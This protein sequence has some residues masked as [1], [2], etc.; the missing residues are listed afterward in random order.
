MGAASTST[1]TGT[2][3]GTN[4]NDDKGGKPD[5]SK[6]GKGAKPDPDSTAA[7]AAGDDD[8]EQ[9]KAMARKHEREN[10]R[11]LKEL[12][13]IRTANESETEKKIREAKDEGRREATAELSKTLVSEAI[14]SEAAT[15]LADADD[16]ALISAD[17]RETFVDD[18]G[19]IDRK[20]IQAA[21]DSLVKA[22][23][24]L[25]PKGKAAP[26]PG[27]AGTSSGTIDLN[28]EIRRRVG[29]F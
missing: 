15:R 9:W 25:G 10:K 23:P 21:L 20:A 3:T 11:L 29:K 16:A 14:R 7:A 24:Y 8:G 1:D 19:N 6:E 2:D 18:K 28:A 5:P 26:L 22:K 17:V 4:G 13:D 27:G 12:E